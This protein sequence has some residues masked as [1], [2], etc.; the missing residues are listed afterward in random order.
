MSSSIFFKNKNKGLPREALAKWG[1][2]LV[3]LIV[4]MSIATVIMTALIIQQSKWNDRLTVNTQAYE[5]AL[6][7]RQAQIYS[8]GVRED[9]AGGGGFD[10]GYGVYFDKDYV[11]V[12]GKINRYIFFADKNNADI[13]KYDAG[14]AIIETKTF[15]RGVIIDEFCGTKGNG[16]NDDRCAPGAGNVVMLNITFFRPDP[17]ANI[18]FLNNGGQST[19][20]IPPAKIYLKSLG[21]KEYSVNVEA[22]GQ[23]SIIQI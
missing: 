20:I 21:G 2:T 6:M 9:M 11:D 18:L 13:G 4:V 16:Q 10:V 23:I 17:K 5:L 1:F 8:L 7:I 14:D 15:T 22:N 3:E 12:N 19:N